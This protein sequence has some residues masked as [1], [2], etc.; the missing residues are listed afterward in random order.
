[1]N[2]TD[3][4]NLGL[5]KVLKQL[6]PGYSITLEALQFITEFDYELI[7]HILKSY[8]ATTYIQKIVYNILGEKLNKHAIS[9][10]TKAVFRY[11]KS[12]KDGKTRSEMSCLQFSVLLIE[13]IIKEIAPNFIFNNEFVIYITAVLEYISAE[14]LELSGIE[15]RNDNLN[16]ITIKHIKT[17]ISKDDELKILSKEIN[18]DIYVLGLPNQSDI[19]TSIILKENEELRDSNFMKIYEK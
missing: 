16:I 6:H 5:F 14:L 9:E 8:N 15:A 12:S 19:P 1:M 10:G 2:D 11:E 4:F 13:R 17:A 18:T 3:N 7:Y